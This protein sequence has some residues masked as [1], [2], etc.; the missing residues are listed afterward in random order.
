MAGGIGI[1][2]LTLPQTIELAKRHGFS[3]I[4]FNIVEASQLAEE[5][6][7][8][9]VKD[10]FTSAG[11]RAGG[12]GSGVN[13]RGAEEEFASS[14]Q[15]L[16][17]YADLALELGSDRALGGLGPA[18]DELDYQANFAFQVD[19]IGRMAR[20]LAEHGCRYGIEFIG[21]KHFRESRKYEFIYTAEGVMELARAI[22]AG[23]V[24]L[25]LDVW[26]LYT[27]GGQISDIKKFS[28]K[29]IVAVHVN[30]AP[31]DVEREAQRD[32]VRMM[33]LE[34]GVLD[35]MGFLGELKTLGYDGPVT[36]EPFSARI[37]S[38]PA[39]EAATETI[40]TMRRLFQV[41]GITE[42]H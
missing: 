23:N 25:L 17:K 12:W 21:P 39:E 4:D 27:S 11:V 8:A 38:L 3:G 26:H 28:A 24:G 22:G 20:I 7:K 15:N 33:P 42:S 10:L 32:N 19:R 1:K 14:L 6:G 40:Q 18:S 36:C 35:L 29:D 13:G 31:K 37:N 34:T 9:Y 2:G 41:A 5:K 30:D 16:P